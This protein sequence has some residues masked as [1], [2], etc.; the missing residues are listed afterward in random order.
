MNMTYKVIAI[1]AILISIACTDKKSHINSLKSETTVQ[2]KET[3]NIKNKSFLLTIEYQKLASY[4]WFKKDSSIVNDEFD[5]WLESTFYFSKE[6]WITTSYS[7]TTGKHPNYLESNSNEIL[8]NYPIRLGDPLKK[9]I[10]SGKMKLDLDE[11]SMLLLRSGEYEFFLDCTDKID[12]ILFEKLQNCI[13]SN[14]IENFPKNLND[15]K[16]IRFRA[17]KNS[18]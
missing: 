12:D 5:E 16:I 18:L 6:E 1:L 7:D 11:N 14:A 4:K 9:V 2:R 10:L 3:I 13:A 8:G 15:C 17:Y